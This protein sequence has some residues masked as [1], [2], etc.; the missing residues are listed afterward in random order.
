MTGIFRSNPIAAIIIALVI[1]YFVGVPMPIIGG[2]PCTLWFKVALY[3]P[4]PYSMCF[5]FGSA[6]WAY[7]PR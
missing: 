2:N 6:A 3:V 1:L 5:D 4:A 7:L